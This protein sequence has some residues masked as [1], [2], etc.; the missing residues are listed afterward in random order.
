MLRDWPVF[1]ELYD[2]LHEVLPPGRPRSLPASLAAIA[3]LRRLRP[4]VSLVTFPSLSFH[5]NLL[6]FLTGA[7]VRIG[8]VYPDDGPASLSWLNTVRRPVTVGLHDVPQNLELVRLLGEPRETFTDL[9]AAAPAYHRPKQRLVG[10][11]TGCNHAQAHKQ[12]GMERWA[13][14]V[15]RLLSD[16]IPYGIRMFFG[17]DERDQLDFFRR[18]P[19]A[20]QVELVEAPD[21]LDAC[22]S[23]GDC[24]VFAS[25]DSG[26]MHLAVLTGCP[27]VIAVCGPSDPRRTGPF[28]PRARILAADLPCMP[29]SHSYTLASRR[30]RCVR[31]IRTE[32]LARVAEDTVHEAIWTAV[33]KGGPA[34]AVPA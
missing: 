19:W 1:R 10:F 11:H 29:C 18:Q 14:V 21:L 27:D 34:P 26:L 3:K 24:A 15:Q 32:C 23:I 12:W 20:D 30:F 6:G 22:R 28:D 16:R 25:N 33:G 9:S 31:P 8:S 2:G 13:R 7:P 17:P 4:T 5:Y